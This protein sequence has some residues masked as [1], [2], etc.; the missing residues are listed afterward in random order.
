MSQIMVGVTQDL[1]SLNDAQRLH[2]HCFV[3]GSSIDVPAGLGISYSPV[4]EQ[5]VQAEFVVE[6]RHQGYQGLL[7]GGIASSLIDGAMTHCLLQQNIPALTAEL[8]MRFHQPIKLGD[9]VN[10]SATVT[11]Q[12]RG[13]YCVEG[14]LTVSGLCCVSSKAKFLQ[15]K[16]A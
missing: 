7:H 4:D 16:L 6:V 12:R 13:I 3:C 15:P 10:I 2:Q 5:S 1:D 11:R 9:T 8:N 14:E